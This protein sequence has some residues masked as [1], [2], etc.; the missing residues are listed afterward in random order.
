MNIRA[1]TT[2]E[3]RGRPG[4]CVQGFAGGANWSFSGP[5]SSATARKSRLHTIENTEE[6]GRGARIRTADLLRPRQVTK[7][8]LVDSEALSLAADSPFY[9]VFLACWPQVGPT[10][11]LLCYACRKRLR[12]QTWGNSSKV[13]LD[14]SYWSS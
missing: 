12:R 8:Y 6:I 5:S 7:H 9:P 11:D 14:I 10:G 1:Y 4:Q 13:S 3:H 2:S